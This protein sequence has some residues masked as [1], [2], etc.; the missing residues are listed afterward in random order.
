MYEKDIEKAVCEYARKKDFL[1]YKFVSPAHMAVPDRL[2]ITPKGNCFFIEFKAPGK[3]ATPQQ[4]REHN[5]LLVHFMDVNVIDN[6]AHG[7][8]LI[9]Y[10]EE[11]EQ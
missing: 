2:F 10:Y 5:R 8:E 6:V 7:K 11:L 1:A 3:H 9:D 4:L